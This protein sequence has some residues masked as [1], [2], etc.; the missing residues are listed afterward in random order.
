MVLYATDPT[1][2]PFNCSILTGNT[3]LP[4]TCLPDT[5]GK[6]QYLDENA[7][8]RL[9]SILTNSLVNEARV[10]NPAQRCVRKNLGS[11]HRYAGWHHA[12]TSGSQLPRPNH[13]QW[14]CLPSVRLKW[15][16]STNMHIAG[17]LPTRF[18]GT[19]GM[20]TIRAGL[21]VERDR[22]DTTQPR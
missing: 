15:S 21:E 9:T 13:R 18:P 2:Y 19:T 20:H 17:R 1:V 6:A 14:T 12:D 16:R 4:S 10:S 22:I 5:A 7:L 11:I 3:T 8:I